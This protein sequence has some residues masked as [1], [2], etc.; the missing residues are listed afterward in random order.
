MEELDAQVTKNLSFS[1]LARWPQGTIGLPDTC[2]GPISSSQDPSL[3]ARDPRP[4]PSVARRNLRRR[5]LARSFIVEAFACSPSCS[6]NSE[7]VT[8]ALMISSK[9]ESIKLAMQSI[10][11]VQKEHTALTTCPLSNNLLLLTKNDER[12]VPLTRS[13]PPRQQRTAT[14]TTSFRSHHSAKT[15]SHHGG[16]GKASKAG[17][18][19]E[20]KSLRAGAPVYRNAH[21][22]CAGA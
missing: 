11:G 5:P 6:N 4:L 9:S 14:E 15:A 22:R 1:P 13:T 12:K 2:R 19:A 18:R 17:E 21:W 3:V 7:T 16:S 20:A 8:F 10:T